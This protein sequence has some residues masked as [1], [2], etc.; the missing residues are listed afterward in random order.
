MFVRLDDISEKLTG[1]F[2]FTLVCPLSLET[3]PDLSHLSVLWSLPQE[4]GVML[5]SREE[6]RHLL[7]FEFQNPKSLGKPK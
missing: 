3:L 5:E 4:R 1:H 6:R 7:A 2:F